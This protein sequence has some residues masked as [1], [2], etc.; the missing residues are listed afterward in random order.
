MG[1]FDLDEFVVPVEKK[2]LVD[3]IQEIL[4]KNPFA[5][6]VAINWY[7]YGSA[8]H[9]TK[10]E[11]LVMENYLYRAKDDYRNN[12]CVKTVV[13]PRLTKGYIFDPHTPTYFLWIS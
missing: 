4:N 6:G 10:P 2:T 9:K 8:G 1:F 11:G 12:H 3:V 5:G 7:V 13:N